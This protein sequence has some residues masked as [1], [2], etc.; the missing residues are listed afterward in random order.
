MTALTG[1]RSSLQYEIT[2]N[3]KLKKK[4]EKAVSMRNRP[5]NTLGLR[6]VV[7]DDDDDDDDGGGGG[8]RTCTFIISKRLSIVLTTLIFPSVVNN[9]TPPALQQSQSVYHFFGYKN[10]D[11]RL[12]YLR[13]E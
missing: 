12:S 2:K 5:Q 6:E 13:S 4:N 10:I 1:N 8:N 9:S 3:A 7:S 11:I